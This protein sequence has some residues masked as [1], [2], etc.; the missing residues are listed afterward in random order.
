MQ[1]LGYLPKQKD[2]VSVS[3]MQRLTKNYALLLMLLAL[4]GG[5]THTVQHDMLPDAPSIE[6]AAH[7]VHIETDCLLGDLAAAPNCDA[8]FSISFAVL[9]QP[10]HPPLTAP[11]PTPHRSQL[12]RAPPVSV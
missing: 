7:E 3:A 2:G 10:I 6:S 11:R 9:P 8:T 4:L 5:V 12:A 1:R